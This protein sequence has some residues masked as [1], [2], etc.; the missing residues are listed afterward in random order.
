MLNLALTILTRKT[1]KNILTRSLITLDTF[2]TPFEN[3]EVVIV[4][5]F[6]RSDTTVYLS[7]SVSII[8][9]TE[10]IILFWLY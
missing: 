5:A 2:F 3:S 4:G 6:T 10:N 1:L 8:V 7:I 9:S